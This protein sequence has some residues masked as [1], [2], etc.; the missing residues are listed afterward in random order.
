MALTFD[1][2]KYVSSDGAIKP[3]K[4]V[5]SIEWVITMYYS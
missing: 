1:I 2:Q 5:M 3:Q 4:L